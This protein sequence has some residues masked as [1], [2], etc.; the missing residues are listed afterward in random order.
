M[1]FFIAVIV[2]SL[3][4]LHELAR[5]LAKRHYLVLSASLEQVIASKANGE[6]AAFPSLLTFLSTWW[7]TD[8]PVLGRPVLAPPPLVCRAGDAQAAILLNKMNLTLKAELC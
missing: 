4:A 6:T 2:G 1:L 7:E 5:A 8:Q 3:N